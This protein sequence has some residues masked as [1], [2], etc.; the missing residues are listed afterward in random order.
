MDF[1]TKLCNVNS[2]QTPVFFFH[3]YLCHFLTDYD[4]L[5]TY[6]EGKNVLQDACTR[7]TNVFPFNIHDRNLRL[8][9]PIPSV[10][11]WEERIWIWQCALFKLRLWLLKDYFYRR[12]DLKIFPR[13]LRVWGCKVSFS[14]FR[15]D[16][17]TPRDE[18][19][20]L[21]STLSNLRCFFLCLLLI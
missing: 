5:Y 13:K 10:T 8:V 2:W 12:K 17:E 3:W 14:Q 18:S 16:T 1:H 6:S 21:H 11:V 15:H 9:K 20:V 7:K 4:N 19:W